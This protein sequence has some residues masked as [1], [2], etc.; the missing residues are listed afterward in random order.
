M[1]QY[2]IYR[3]LLILCLFITATAAMGQGVLSDHIDTE[4]DRASTL[5]ALE[6]S[7]QKAARKNDH[8]TAM[9]RYL[10]VLEVDSLHVGALLGYG[11][12]AEKSASFEKAAWAYQ[13][14]VNNKL[15][16]KE[17]EAILKLA[18]MQ[19]QMGEYAAAKQSYQQFLANPDIKNVSPASIDMVQDRMDDCDW[20]LQMTPTMLLKTPLMLLDT[21]SVNSI[22]SEYSPFP[23]GDTLYFSSYR[24][25]YENDR[26]FPKRRLI[27]VMTAT[28]AGANLDVSET[29]FNQKNKH[30]AHV[31]FNA[32]GDVMYYTVGEFVNTATI[33]SEIF[34]RK[35]QPTGFWGP[36]ER[37]PGY[38]NISGYTST[39]P[40][41]GLDADG[42][43]EVLLFVSDCPNG[44]GKRDIWFSRI[45]G[46]SLS[47]PVNLAEINTPGDDVTPFYHTPAGMLYFSTDGRQ[48]L[49]GLD[50]Y[51]AKGAP[52][53]LWDAPEHLRTPINSGYNDVYFTLTESGQSIFMSSNRRGEHNTSEEACCYDIY[54]ADLVAPRMIAVAFNKL[55]GDS[56]SGTSM[57]LLELDSKGNVVNERLVT[58]DGPYANFELQPGKKYAIIGTKNR[59]SNDT[60]YFETPKVIWK[61]LMVQKLYLAPAQVNLVAK[62]FDL[63]TKQPIQGSS[64]RFFEFPPDTPILSGIPPK[65]QET[66]SSGN[67]YNYA[68]DFDKRYKVVVSKPGYTV[69]S[70]NIIS[71]VGLEKSQTIYDTLYITRGVSLQAHTIDI[72]SKDT[73]S[74]ITYRLVDITDRGKSKIKDQSIIAGTDQYQQVLSFEKRYLL[75]ASKPGYTTDSV[76]LTTLNLKNKEFETIF[77][78]LRLRPLEITAYLP[79]K[80]Y[81][82]NDEPDKRTLKTSTD[83]EY[84]AT[85]VDYI[86][87]KEEFMEAYTAGMAENEKQPAIDSLEFFFEKEV[88]AGWDQLMAFSEILYEMMSR[89]D[90]IEITLKGYASPRAGAQ[91]NLNLTDRR[92]SSVYNHFDLFDGGIY[93]KF[94]LS[95]QLVIKREANGESKSPKG[96]SDN[97]QD[98]KKSVYDVRASRERRL[99]I[100]GVKVNREKKL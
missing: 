54:K 2:I 57:R 34:R 89:G 44:K 41:I 3:P 68:L 40:N 69:D 6:K 4:P 93:K 77:R 76:S 20:A 1:V 95:G 55:S 71:T 15:Y 46:D 28:Q 37:L 92:V 60:T 62:V 85:Y 86:R 8:A 11:E 80:L 82:D 24:F 75:Y 10:K 98:R 21:P 18:N 65:K 56:L 25:D 48:T 66:N 58:L 16:G 83:R 38:I 19:Y 52:G 9:H 32:K 94:V 81:F 64:A 31:T 22:Y 42:K 12:A 84:R 74:G 36:E 72:M 96:I 51:V 35:M 59:Y 45:F 73:L 30:T 47:A 33:R 91:Y 39:E 43:T 99:E 78:E 67:Q 17:G 88:R 70:T 13:R 23:K 14:L 61:D 87:K 50:V 26:H 90:S 49:G 27:K 7:A 79:I 53:S 97:I 5:A 100:I 63:E 29:D